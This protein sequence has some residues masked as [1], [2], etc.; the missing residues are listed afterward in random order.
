MNNSLSPTVFRRRVSDH[1]YGAW[2]M[3]HMA[4]EHHA[5]M[6]ADIRTPQRPTWTQAYWEAFCEAHPVAA[7]VIAYAVWYVGA[8]L[9]G[10]AILGAMVAVRV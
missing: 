2:L 10:V 1:A 3:E 8:V 6:A 9:A 7:E 4:Q 5:A